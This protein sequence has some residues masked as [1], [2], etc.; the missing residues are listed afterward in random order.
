M[1]FTYDCQ[2]QLVR[3][4]KIFSRNHMLITRVL[5]TKGFSITTRA[6]L[7]SFGVLSIRTTRNSWV[8]NI[9]GRSLSKNDQTRNI[10]AS[11]SIWRALALFESSAVQT[12]RRKNQR[13]DYMDYL[14]S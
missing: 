12:V 11:G 1:S 4:G 2:M 13:S 14:L 6:I 8:Q 3:L 7:H 10:V 9:L 5:L